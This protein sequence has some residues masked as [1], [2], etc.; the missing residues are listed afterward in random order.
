MT[1]NPNADSLIFSQ[2]ANRTI[3]NTA[4]E[5]SLLGTGAGSNLIKANA[6]TVGKRI[7]IH[8]EG[9]YSTPLVGSSLTIRV[10]LGGVVV[11]SV[12]T[13]ALLASAT[14][15]ACT[16]DCLI[17]VREVGTAGKVIVGGEASYSIGASKFFQDIDNAGAMT[18]LDTTADM[19]P[20]VTVQWD[21]AS[22]TRSITSTIATVMVV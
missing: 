3:T 8:G 13:S 10:K 2:T 17:V 15:K 20:D 21:L 22:T 9:I 1:Y 4:A 6:L 16:F 5:T 18:T 19:S 7:R 11:A 14:N 12:V